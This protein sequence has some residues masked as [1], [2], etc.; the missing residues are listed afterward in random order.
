MNVLYL[1]NKIRALIQADAM[2]IT[3]DDTTST[4]YIFPSIDTV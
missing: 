3:K 4:T 1:N 2:Q